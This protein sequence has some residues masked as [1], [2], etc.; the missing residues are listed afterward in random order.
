LERP[1]SVRQLALLVLVLALLAERLLLDLEPVGQLALLVRLVLLG[2]LELPRA[3]LDQ[4]LVFG[5]PLIEFT[6]LQYKRFIH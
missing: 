3:V 4:Q 2:Q 6:P 5:Y 1:V